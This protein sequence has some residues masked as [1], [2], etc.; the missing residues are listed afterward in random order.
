MCVNGIHDTQVI[1]EGGT[2]SM[3]RKMKKGTEY[4]VVDL[5]I[6]M[7]EDTPATASDSCRIVFLLWHGT[8]R[9]AA[10]TASG[11]CF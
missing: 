2:K 3:R 1:G 4:V 9:I 7:E 8:N 11:S 10:P 5:C 6:D